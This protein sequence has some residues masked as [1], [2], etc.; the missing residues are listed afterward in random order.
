[1]SSE[2]QIPSIYRLWHL[3]IEPAAACQG[4]VMAARSPLL[5]LGVMSPAANR[6]HYHPELQVVFDQLAATYFLF[7]FNQ[8]VVLR[9]VGANLAVWRTMITGMLLCDV[10]HVAATVK[11]LG[12]ERV[13]DPSV[14]RL[15]DWVNILMLLASLAIRTAFLAGVGVCERFKRCKTALFMTFVFVYRI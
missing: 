3:Y 5:Y 13:L 15:F 9:V 2:S 14:W 7:A 8:A 10:F 4:A 11:A 12:W 6:S 1:M